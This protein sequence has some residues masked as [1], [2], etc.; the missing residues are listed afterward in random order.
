MID[1]QKIMA[2]K[3]Y[4]EKRDDVVMAFLFR[5]RAKNQTRAASDWDVGV[6]FKPKQNNVEWEEEKYYPEENRVWADCTDIL[7]AD[8]IDL[9]VLNR[10]SAGIADSVI[11]GTPLVVKDYGLWLKF[12]LRV[13][14]LAEEYRL[15]V[16]DFYEIAERS[17][18]LAAQ[19]AE[20][21]RRAIRFIEE[22]VSLYGVYQ[23]FSQKEYEENPRQRNEMERWLENIINAVIDISKIVLGS[24]K[25]LIPLTYRETVAGAIRAFELPAEFV[26]TF[27]Q[28][29]RIRNDLAHEYLDLKWKRLFDF[30]GASESAIRAFI[31][32][33]KKFLDAG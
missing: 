7:G 22:Q 2:L 12:M 3:E 23:A 31:D 6:Y 5:S 8:A 28:W 25:M 17:H 20:H 1:D 26:I 11:R 14:A 27:E 29:V 33:A 18:S 24:K 32:A 30:A 21:L 15:F 4:F 19:D 10:A 9:V 16:K 13:T